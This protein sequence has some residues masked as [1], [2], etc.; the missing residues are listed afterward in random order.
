MTMPANAF[1][2]LQQ[3]ALVTLRTLIGWHF[4]YEGYTKLLHPA[5]GRAGVPLADWSSAGYLKAATGPLAGVFHAL[6]NSSWVGSLDAAVAWLLVAVGLS[7]ML[8][9]F[10]Q[11]G[12]VGALGLLAM[13]YVSAIP[14]G[15][16]E[17]RA[18]G[19]YLI[20]NKNLIEAAAVLV[21]LSFRTGQIAGI[22]QYWRARTADVA[23]SD[24][25]TDDAPRVASG[26]SRKIF[27]LKAEAT[28]DFQQPR[29][30]TLL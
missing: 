20:V 3:A 15:L 7:L 8:G 10:T 6:G 14:T 26:F 5:W 9:L 1:G 23:G 19:T 28:R 17:A 30:S 2:G 22:D 27:R 21:L 18:E 25:V 24:R 12:C 29:E 4:L 13:F 16:P 11:A